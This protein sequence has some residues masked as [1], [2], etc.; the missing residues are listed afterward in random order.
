MKFR[1]NN[2]ELACLNGSVAPVFPKYTSQLINWANQN[3]R[4][5]RPKVVGQ[6]SEMF[7][8]YRSQT[9][10]VSLDGWSKWYDEHNPNAIEQ[11]TDKIMLHVAN[12]KKAITLI[13]RDM[14]KSWVN[15][16]VI[17]KTYNGLYVQEAILL[18][19]AEQMGEPYRPASP[20]ETARGING[21]VGDTA[22]AVK[23]SSFKSMDRLPEAVNVKMIFYTKSNTGLSVEVEE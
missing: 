1:I 18:K 9:D 20:Q 3:A 23:P 22:Y 5:T 15:D 2:D 21:Y 17:A 4:G 7:P 12:L 10:N 14:V 13:D 8:E 11:A 6:L 16:L 19:L